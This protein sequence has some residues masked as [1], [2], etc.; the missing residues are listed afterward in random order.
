MG[1]QLQTLTN[2]MAPGYAGVSEYLVVSVTVVSELSLCLFFRISGIGPN[3]GIPP[4]A[5]PDFKQF[6]D[7]F[8][9]DLLFRME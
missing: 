2:F 4:L 3:M 8:Q 1:M 7:G 5:V 9:C 6:G